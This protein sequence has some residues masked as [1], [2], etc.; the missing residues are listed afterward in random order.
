MAL[1]ESILKD[2]AV[3]L[4]VELKEALNSERVCDR[5]VGVDGK[6][7]VVIVKRPAIKIGFLFFEELLGFDGCRAVG[8]S[9]DDLGGFAH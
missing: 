6:L 2:D 4:A 3:V 8:F 5:V 1:C 7:A 9:F